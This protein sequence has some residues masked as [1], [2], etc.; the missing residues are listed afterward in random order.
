MCVHKVA[1]RSLLLS[2]SFLQGY[3]GAPGAQGPPGHEGERVSQQIRSM[4]KVS[5]FEMFYYAFI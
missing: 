2:A 1:H 4:R 3:S 5:L